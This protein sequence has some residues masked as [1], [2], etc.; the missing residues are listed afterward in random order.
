MQTELG[1]VVNST[2]NELNPNE[3]DKDASAIAR[4]G[5]EAKNGVIVIATKKDA[6]QK[7]RK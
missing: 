2:L 5:R 6:P 7:T 1:K 4:Y 3:I